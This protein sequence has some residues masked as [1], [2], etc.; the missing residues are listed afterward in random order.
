MD[1]IGSDSVN[2]IVKNSFVN[3]KIGILTEFLLN[4]IIKGFGD[5]DSIQRPI[6]LTRI[7]YS[8][9]WISNYIHYKIWDEISLPFINFNGATVE[10]WEWINDFFQP[11]T[12]YVIT[13]TCWD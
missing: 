10:V 8:S 13:Y 2:E 5:D 4:I 6:L 12:W 7:N 9:A 11:F 1:Q 3:E